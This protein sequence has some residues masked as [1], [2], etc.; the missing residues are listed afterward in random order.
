[1][2]LNINTNKE[3]NKEIEEILSIPDGDAWALYVPKIPSGK[4]LL[5]KRKDYRN[6]DCIDYAF[7]INHRNCQTA[8]CLKMLPKLIE[9]QEKD[10]VLYRLS[11]KENKIVHAGIYQKDTTIIS[12]WGWGGPIFN[13]PIDFVP[14]FYGDSVT[15]HRISK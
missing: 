13:H 14:H 8:N 11:E 4:I 12:R 2:K 6:Q 15:F 3:I 7:N 5:I 9:P 10:I 1:M